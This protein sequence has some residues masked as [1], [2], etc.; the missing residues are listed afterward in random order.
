MTVCA[1]EDISRTGFSAHATA[2]ALREVNPGLN[3]HTL[4]IS[5]KHTLQMNMLSSDNSLAATLGSELAITFFCSTNVMT[6]RLRYE[7]FVK[8]P[9]L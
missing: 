1:V 8:P 2:Q 7:T 9:C 4:S 6:E 3:V 5:D